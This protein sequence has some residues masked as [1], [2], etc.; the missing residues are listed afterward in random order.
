MPQSQSDDTA[1]RLAVLEES[2][3]E[4]TVS[5]TTLRAQ[6]VLIGALAAMGAG[7]AATGGSIVLQNR[8]RIDVLESKQRDMERVQ[9]E[10]QTEQRA[11]TQTLSDLRTDLR[12]IGTQLS[13]VRERAARIEEQ[14]NRPVLGAVMRR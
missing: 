3:R 14:L 1:R 12:V 11:L 9:R 5:T 10:T 4:H 2:D 13:E 7:A 8:S 6:W